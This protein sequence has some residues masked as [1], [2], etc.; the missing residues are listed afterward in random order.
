MAESI[1]IILCGHQ[2]EVFQT[3][4]TNIAMIGGV[5]SGKTFMEYLKIHNHV[6]EYPGT[7][8]ALLM[9]SFK[10]AD[11]KLRKEYARAFEPYIKTNNSG[12]IEY[13]NGS[14]VRFLHAWDDIKGVGHL[15]GYSVSAFMLSEACKMPAETWGKMLE[16]CRRIQTDNFKPIVSIKTGKQITMN[17]MLHLV[18]GNPAGRDYVYKLWV[19]GARCKTYLEKARDGKLVEYKVY[20]KEV[21]TEDGLDK[22]ILVNTEQADY[23]FVPKGYTAKSRV[24]KSARHIKR[25]GKGSFD[26][27]S[28]V[29]YTDFDENKHVLHDLFNITSVLPNRYAR[30]VGHDWGR[31][32]ESAWVW[33]IYDRIG[34][35][36]LWYKESYE[37]GLV[38]EQQAELF[39]KEN[40]NDPVNI[41]IADNQIW[42]VD[43][44]TG[45]SIA[46]TYQ[47]V[48]EEAGMYINLVPADKGPGSIK[49][50]ID[51]LTRYIKL[52]K[53]MYFD[54]LTNTFWEFENYKYGD[55]LENRPPK[56]NLSEI[57][58][59]K[60]N[61]LMD[62]YRYV[63]DA[64]GLYDKM[65]ETLR[66]N[67]SSG[68]GKVEESL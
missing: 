11:G 36:Y 51:T 39:L 21:Q 14:I 56:K 8:A 62:A 12:M 34:D 20:E 10:D 41:V 6:V 60:H 28:G 17:E 15:D 22:Y 19:K 64:K 50:G 61:H 4:A 47:K 53:S 13:H 25:Y 35:S 49:R 7:E 40:N 44:I 52:G 26:D 65:D 46:E 30:V 37:A 29:V 23:E 42:Q 5:G 2:A 38:A 54:T 16:R 18:E 59:D 24:G 32:T 43:P 31:R 33:G 63:V 1:D 27:Y 55:D 58:L 9:R 66:E 48:W 67:K 3:D 45:G 57:P 68:V